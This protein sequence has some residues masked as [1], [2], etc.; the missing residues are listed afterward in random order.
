[1]L[2]S[3]PSRIS[4]ARRLPFVAFQALLAIALAA[5]CTPAYNWRTVTD[6]AEGYAID[7][8]AKPTVDER[9]VEIAGS[10]LPMHVRAA[11]AQGAVF[12]IAAIDLPRDDGQL[13]QAVVDALRSALARN[14][15]SQPVEHPVKIPA[16]AG[17]AVPGVDVVAT[18][19]AG[20]AHEQRTIHAWIAARGRHV[21]QA[22]IVAAHA[23]PQEQSEQ[24]FGSLT[25]Q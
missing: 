20:A 15:G 14:L 23:P 11:N 21:Y 22:I 2:V 24:F 7:L 13:R 18:G 12:A 3:L 4:R 16:T 10:A 1:M 9:Q 8:P 17:A 5:A 19:G 25:L 6:Q